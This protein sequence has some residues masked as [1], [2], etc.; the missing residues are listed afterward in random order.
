MKLIFSFVIVVLGL[1][2]VIALQPEGIDQLVEIAQSVREQTHLIQKPISA[3]DPTLVHKYAEDARRR[4]E[5]VA[6][7]QPEAL[8]R[9][10]DRKSVV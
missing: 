1:F 4:A 10:G 2:I 5:A 8:K 7:E 3:L 9:Q 6:R